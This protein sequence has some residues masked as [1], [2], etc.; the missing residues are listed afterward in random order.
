MPFLGVQPSRGLVGSSGIDNNSIDSQ[1]YANGSI[2]TAHIAANQIDGT[3][4]KDALIADYS[5]VTIT[6]ADLIMY[7]DATDS[8]NTKRDTVQGILDLAGG[9][10]VYLGSATASNS[11]TVDLESMIDNTKYDVH[12]I[13]ISGVQPASGSTLRMRFSDD[14][15]TSYESANY[16]YCYVYMDDSSSTVSGENAGAGAAFVGMG[17]YRTI[18]ADSDG[19]YGNEITLYHFKDTTKDPFVTFTGGFSHDA[20]DDN[21]IFMGSGSLAST[22]AD[23]DAVR[24]YQSSGNISVGEFRIY[25]VVNS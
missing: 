15:G 16:K 4:T 1:H 18:G 13:F 12:K 11:S 7:G 20:E 25:G 2:D 24:F 8:N 14:N 10:L 21:V 23:I 9:G 22:G 17:D 19:N 6:A 5:D 3:L